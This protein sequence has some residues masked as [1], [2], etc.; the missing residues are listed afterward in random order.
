[1]E[2]DA[3][4]YEILGLT[5]QSRLVCKHI[6]NSLRHSYHHKNPEF[7]TLDTI[8]EMLNKNFEILSRGYTGYTAC[9]VQNEIFQNRSRHHFAI[10]QHAKR[11]SYNYITKT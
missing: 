5:E 6:T 4:I 9:V 10:A 11:M 3:K 7:S 8:S 2:R 1:M